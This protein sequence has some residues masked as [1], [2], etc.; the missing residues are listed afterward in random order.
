MS[1]AICLFVQLKF[2]SC[3]LGGRGGFAGRT[4]SHKVKAEYGSYDHWN[5]LAAK[6][7]RPANKKD[8]TAGEIGR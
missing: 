8:P 7:T 5:A 3:V 4:L 6:K 1:I 2:V